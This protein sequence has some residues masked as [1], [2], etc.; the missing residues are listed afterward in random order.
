MLEK[1]LK[2]LKFGFKNSR[3]LKGL[4][5]DERPV[6]V[7]E[8]SVGCKVQSLKIVLANNSSSLQVLYVYH[9][10]CCSGVNFNSIFATYY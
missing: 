6:K 1:S 8:K 4:E 7:L 9:W 3:P 10:L 2:M 5:T